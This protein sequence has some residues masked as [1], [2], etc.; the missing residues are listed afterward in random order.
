[1]IR[2]DDSAP[3]IKERLDAYERQ[4]QPLIEYFQEKGRRLLEIDASSDP[5]QELVQKICRAIREEGRGNAG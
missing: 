1:M 2:A 5:P 3:V 4:T